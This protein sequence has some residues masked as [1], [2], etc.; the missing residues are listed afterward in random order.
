[1][2]ITTFATEKGHAMKDVTIEMVQ[3]E[4]GVEKWKLNFE[5]KLKAAR[6]PGMYPDDWMEA[7]VK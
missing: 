6:T 7:V 2:G 1:M 3:A 5:E 4:G